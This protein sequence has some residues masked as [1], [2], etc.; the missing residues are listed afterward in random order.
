MLDL[1]YL[2]CDQ[3]NLD[4]PEED[5][6]EFINSFFEKEGSNQINEQDKTSD[7]GETENAAENDTRKPDDVKISEES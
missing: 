1:V 7:S 6:K 5:F 3:S 2:F 4:K